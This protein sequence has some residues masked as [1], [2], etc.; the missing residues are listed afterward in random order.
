MKIKAETPSRPQHNGT[1]I[2]S[3]GSPGVSGSMK[4]GAVSMFGSGAVMSGCVFD[5]FTV[6]GGDF[7]SGMIA[8]RAVSFF[9]P[10]NG[11]IFG[12][13]GGT[14]GTDGAF[15]AIMGGA[16]GI[17]G[18]STIGSAMDG[19]C[20]G[21]GAGSAIEG[22]GNEGGFGAC[23]R[24]GNTGG[25]GGFKFCDDFEELFGA[26]EGRLILIVSRGRPSG[27]EALSA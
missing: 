5:I 9:G 15:C 6:L 13:G 18:E 23:P 17:S 4:M 20:S 12:G 22:T 10:G 16:G 2:D 8:I 24:P 1:E 21:D 14:T 3:I 27:V 11:F 26:R 7:G 25:P 19:V